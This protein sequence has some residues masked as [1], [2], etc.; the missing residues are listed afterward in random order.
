M[1]VVDPTE[2]AVP[3][4]LLPADGRFGSG[5]SKVRTGQVDALVAGATDLLGTSHRKPPVK[6][7]VAAIRRG[8]VELFALPEGW[9]IVLGNGGTTTFWDIATFG[10]IEERSQ[11]LVFGEFSAKFADAVASAPHLADPIVVTSEPGDHPE[12]T[13]GDGIDLHA[14]THNETSTGVAM[15]LRRPAASDGALVAVDATSAAGGMMW[16][17]AQVDVY[18][19]APQKCFAADGGLWLAACGPAAVERIERIAGV[20]SLGAGIARPR[21]RPLQQQTRPDLQHA[22]GGDADHARRSDRVDARQRRA[23]EH[24]GA[25]DTS[26][27]ATCTPGRRRRTGRRRSSSIPASAVRWSARSMSTTRSMPTR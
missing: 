10:L 5:P 2:I 16:D 7:L 1:T 6:N 4:E 20:R 25:L 9:E 23:G 17:P 3:A 18:Y 13:A 24:G 21:Y 27:R 19:F 11:H 22:G 12:P 26:R 8:L 15:P 14:L